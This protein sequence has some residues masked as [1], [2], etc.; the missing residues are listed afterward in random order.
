MFNEVKLTLAGQQTVEGLGPFLQ[1]F[2]T[3]LPLLTVAHLTPLT[4]E[5]K[6]RPPF[7]SAVD[8]DHMRI[9]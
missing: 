8:Q 7:C 2:S 6:V 3:D 5:E 4:H 1:L 9:H